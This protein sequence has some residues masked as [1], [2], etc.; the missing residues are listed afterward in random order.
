VDRIRGVAGEVLSVTK[1][2][3]FATGCFALVPGGGF[4]WFWREEQKTVF[5]HP[6]LLRSCG[7]RHAKSFLLFFISLLFVCHNFEFNYNSIIIDIE[8]DTHDTHATT[9]ADTLKLSS[10]YHS[11]TNAP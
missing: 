7:F 11:S 9:L 2:R 10:S 5:V 3:D 1:R 4:N 6:P 8:H